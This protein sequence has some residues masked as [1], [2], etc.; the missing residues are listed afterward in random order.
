[1]EILNYFSLS[2]ALYKLLLSF[3][4]AEVKYNYKN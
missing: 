2:I 1:L 3:N 4:H